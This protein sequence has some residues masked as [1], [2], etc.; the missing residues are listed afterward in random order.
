MKFL[1]Y[2]L[3][4]SILLIISCSSEQNIVQEDR[5]IIVDEHIVK[6]LD[7]FKIAYEAN[8]NIPEFASELEHAKLLMNSS[9]PEEALEVLSKIGFDENSFKD[10]SNSCRK[11][12]N[13]FGSNMN[14]IETYLENRLS[15]MIS[16]TDT[17]DKYEFLKNKTAVRTPCWWISAR[18]VL[19]STLYV[20]AGCV[21]DGPFALA[22]CGTAFAG[23][24]IEI[25][26]ATYELCNSPECGC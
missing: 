26:D 22:T 21:A 10:F 7:F 8:K 16:K 11:I 24:A 1:N 25:G 3:I 15:V 23:A 13:E 5:N 20:V 9:K 19:K 14:E 17:I 2:F 18:A 6:A 4:S 12:Q